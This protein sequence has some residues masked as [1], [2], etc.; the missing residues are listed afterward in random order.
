MNA[1]LQPVI[2]ASGALERQS[3]GMLL[4]RMGV[5]ACLIEPLSDGDFRFSRSNRMMDD[6]LCPERGLSGR[7]L[8]DVLPPVVADTLRRH[9]LDCIC[10]RAA[11]DWDGRLS[12]GTVTGWWRTVL[13]PLGNSR[14]RIANILWIVNDATTAKGEE[15]LLREERDRMR[16]AIESINEGFALWDADDRLVLINGRYASF[17]GSLSSMLRPGVRYE[18]LL[19]AAVAAGQFQLDMP[20][21]EWIESRLQAR[22][23]SDFVSEELLRDGRWLLAKERRTSDG[24]TVGLRTEITERKWLEH[25]VRQSRAS[26]QAMIDSVDEMIAMLNDA[27]VVLAINRFGAACFGQQP[28][29]V[30]GRSLLDLVEPEEGQHLRALIR[31]VFDLGARVQREFPWRG[32]IMDVSAHPVLDSKGNP[33]AASVFSCDVTERR[34][35]EDALR[36]LTRAVE[37]SPA[38]VM[39]TNPE[40]LIEYV[41]PRFVEVT[42]YAAKEVLGRSP[43]I[44]RSD[45]LSEQEDAAIWATVK[46]GRTWAGKLRNRRKNGELFWVSASLSPVKN[47]AGEITHFIGL[48]EDITERIAAEEEARDHQQQMM[49]YMRIAAMGE[50]A[51]ALAHELNQ[52]I[53][54]VVN[55]C[56]G[57]LR[58]LAADGWDQDEIVG[59]LKDAHDEAQ[60]AKNII[61]HVARFVRKA[62]QQRVTQSASN[63]V[64]SVVALAK[65]ELERLAIEVVL[66][67]RDDIPPVTVNV[68]ELEQLLLNLIRNSMEAMADIDGDR[69]VLRLTTGLQ[70]VG[71]VVVTVADSGRGFDANNV[72]R[73]FDPFFTSKPQGMGMGL[74]ICRNIAEAHGGR[75]W[76]ETNAEGGASVHFSLPAVEGGHAPV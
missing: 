40:E 8:D 7:R 60:R 52:P 3:F 13:V 61:Q 23:R 46:E 62:P 59:A 18:E 54:A 45:D 75:I 10:S 32:R 12:D 65:R 22:R 71:T 73:A 33:I 21:A 42:G 28:S 26:L 49:R 55:Y 27:G 30:V 15:E 20:A 1:I 29:G 39:I 63:L 2:E 57:S 9:C 68:V 25:V 6:A 51:A 41:N 58:R 19:R 37:Q 50:M 11:L 16:D 67:L 66:D 35:A 53:A 48:Q 44:L 64:R 14:G 5:S 38:I 43:S 34:M 74:A 56:N 70:G 76:A 36:M 4:D 69:Q 72:E 24:G 17:Y 31:S 47:N